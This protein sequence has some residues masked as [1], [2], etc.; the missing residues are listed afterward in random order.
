MWYETKNL[1]TK[2]R[3][4]KLEEK[5]DKLML[6]LWIGIRNCK[7]NKNLEKCHKTSKLTLSV[8]WNKRFVNQ[9]LKENG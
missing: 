3:T 2:C 4:S 9:K 1:E 7:Q 8:K 6:K 5:N